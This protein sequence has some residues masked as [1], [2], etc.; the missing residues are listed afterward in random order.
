M[1]NGN[2]VFAFILKNKS[3]Q[4][5]AWHIDLKEKGE[6]AKGE[7]PI[8]KKADGW[9]IQSLASQNSSRNFERFPLDLMTINI[10][11]EI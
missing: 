8:G 5:E 9:S 10:K 1:K 7:T 4:T 2:A 11:G 6:V 3:G